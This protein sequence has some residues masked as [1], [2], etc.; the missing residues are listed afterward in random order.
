MSRSPHLS[1]VLGAL[2]SVFAGAAC[3]QVTAP[4]LLRGQLERA[5]PDRPVE[6]RA[7]TT[8]GALSSASPFAEDGTF[9]LA[10]PPGHRYQLELGTESGRSLPILGRGHLRGAEVEVCAAEALVDVG[11]LV[12]MTYCPRDPDCLRAQ[13]SV[14]R[15]RT[16]IRDGCMLLEQ[17]VRSCLRTREVACRDP[18]DLLDRCLATRPVGS[19]T[20]QRAQLDRCWLANDCREQERSFLTRC[21]QACA[22]EEMLAEELCMREPTCSGQELGAFV[23]GVLPDRFGCEE[24]S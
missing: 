14:N 12:V 10:L 13:D 24:A 22:G 15:C 20:E 2:S 18:Q 11:R 3:D 5:G 23:G 8:A 19:C 9:L 21:V 16:Q 1:R 7:R 6:A 17:L 4:Q